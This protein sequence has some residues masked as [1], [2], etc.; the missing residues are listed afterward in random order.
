[1][2]QMVISE[3]YEESCN[4]QHLSQDERPGLE[5]LIGGCSDT[6]HSEL[7]WL[8]NIHGFFPYSIPIGHTYAIGAGDAVSDVRKR[9]GTGYWSTVHRL[10]K[11]QGQSRTVGARGSAFLRVEHLAL[12]LVSAVQDIINSGKHPTVGGS[13]QCMIAISDGIIIPQIEAI[14]PT[15]GVSINATTEFGQLRTCSGVPGTFD[16]AEFEWPEFQSSAGQWSGGGRL[17]PRPSTD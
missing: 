1:M 8:R 16:T 5:F 14:G 13:V 17:F 2:A 10:L 11:L 4:S 7:C 9:V 6:V 3:T 12:I 15:D